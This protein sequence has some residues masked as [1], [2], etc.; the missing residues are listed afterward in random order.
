MPYLLDTNILLRLFA[1]DDPRYEEVKVAVDRLRERGE[2][3]SFAPQNAAEFWNVATR[4]VER[5]GFGYTPSE[6]DSL[7]TSA[8]Q[9]APP[10]PDVP[11]MYTHWR[12]LVRE[13]GVSGVQV[14]DARLVAWMQAHGVA[15]L[16]TLNP[17]D[18]SRYVSL[19]DITIVEP[20]EVEARSR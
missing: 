10:L 20:G 8:E 16:L 9:I 5:N 3:L 11:A 17:A 14:H 2:M 13:A 12:R 15:H 1:E 19:A 7:L 4:P 18:F 6:A